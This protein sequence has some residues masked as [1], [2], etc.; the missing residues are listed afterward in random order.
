[1]AHGYRYQGRTDLRLRLLSNLLTF[2]EAVH[3]Q[4]VEFLMINHRCCLVEF[5]LIIMLSSFRLIREA[6]FI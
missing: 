2:V 3:I 5:I 6:Y 4:I 1:M